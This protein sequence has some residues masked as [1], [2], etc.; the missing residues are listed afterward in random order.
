ARVDWAVHRAEAAPDG[1]ETPQGLELLSSQEP[2]ALVL[3][4]RPGTV[5]IESRHP[6]VTIWQA[7][8][9][10]GDGDRF[11]S[12]REALAAGRGERALV[13][14]DGWQVRVD[15]LAPADAR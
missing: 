13:R 8:R 1:P 12:V 7:H 6:I 11:A 2:S 4:L 14:R 5:S 3:R 15:D 9:R 10:S